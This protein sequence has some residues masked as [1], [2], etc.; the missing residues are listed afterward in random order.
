MLP[1]NWLTEAEERLA[2]FLAITP[3]TYDESLDLYLKWENQ[4]V[5][6]S[7][8]ARGALNKAL[9][10]Q[11]WERERGLVTA[12]AGNHGQGLALAGK[13][14]GAQVTIFASEHAVPMK[15]E[16]MRAIGAQVRLVPGGYAEAEQAG[17]ACA[18]ER[19]ATWVSAYNDGQVIAGQGTVALEAL[20]QIPALPQLT[21]IVPVGGGGL[22]SGIAAA[23]KSA[24]SSEFGVKGSSFEKPTS[25]PEH[26]TQNSEL[27][28]PNSEYRT[29]HSELRT[30]FVVGAQS[31]ASA[32]M[33][34][35]Y[36]TGSQ[37]GVLDL[38]SLA[39][40]L[41]GAVEPGSLTITMVRSLV[42]DLILV[43][44]AEIAQAIAYAWEKHGQRIEGAGAVGLAAVLSG[45]IERRPAITVVS[46]GNIQPEVHAEIVG[47]RNLTGRRQKTPLKDLLGLEGP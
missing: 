47:K 16:A 4:Q 14:T 6:G 18:A 8:K 38:P 22:I 28:T 45:R 27:R 3:V 20:R 37:E 24:W 21:W 32:F 1:F 39:D 15:I 23:V 26:Q 12:S 10:L 31:K 25:S 41:A 2:S 40:G 33:H 44:E 9:S 5:T 13:I 43:S 42:D 17:L 35:L 46:G 7:F 36:Y 34:A 29:P 30:D 19:E 11:D